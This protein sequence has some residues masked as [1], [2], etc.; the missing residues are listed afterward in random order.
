MTRA[1]DL[2]N[3]ADGDF[4]GTWTVDGLTVDGDVTL[5]G[6]SYNVVWD[7]SDNALKFADNSQA[8]FGTGADLRVLHDGSNSFIRDTS[9]GNIIIEGSSEVII[10]DYDTSENFLRGVKNG[11]VE[12][13]HNGSVK[14]ATTSTGVA[15][16]G[17]ATFTGSSNF[18]DGNELRFGADNDLAIFHSSGVNNIRSDVGTL[19]LRSDDMRF[20]AQNGTSEF[21]RFDSSGALLVGKTTDTQT[22]VGHVIFGTG[23]AYSTRN[24]FTWL[25]NR[26]STDGEILRLQKDGSTVGSIGTASGY[27]VIG[28][29]VGSDAHLLIGNNLVHPA[30]STGAAKDDSIDIGGSSNRF[31]DLYLSGG[32]QFDSRSNKLDDYEEGTWTPS[33]SAGAISGTSVTLAGTYTKIGRSLLITFEA[34][35][36]AGDISVSSFAQF[37]GLPFTVSKSGTSTVVSEDVDVID[38]QGFATMSGTL[39]SISNSGSSSGT[40]SLRASLVGVV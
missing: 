16:T 4:A 17:G 11:E 34:T 38:R 18:G 26:L 10:R 12:L 24:G 5:T 25:H 39:F 31:K 36:T 20:T 22:D 40:T 35:N 19:K 6:A 9:T 1:R 21:A 13:S 37:S 23:A 15:I 7:K 8:L 30:T 32:I 3:L 28:S 29:P 27:I 14:I 2:A 33:V